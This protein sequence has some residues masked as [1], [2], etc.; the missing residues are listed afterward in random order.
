MATLNGTADDMAAA[1]AELRRC[2]R[3]TRPALPA[4]DPACA[5]RSRPLHI[6]ISIIILVY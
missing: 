1:V 6:I 3:P 5:E 2:R 4:L